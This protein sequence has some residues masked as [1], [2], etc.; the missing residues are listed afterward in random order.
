MK[1]RRATRFV[2]CRS[3]GHSPSRR[4]PIHSRSLVA[5]LALGLVRLSA[6]PEHVQNNQTT[7]ADLSI[8][9]HSNRS[10]DFPEMFSL[11]RLS[12][13]SCSSSGD[14]LHLPQFQGHSHA[15]HG[16]ESLALRAI[17]SAHTVVPRRVLFELLREGD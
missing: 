15:T 1:P 9:I 11:V 7:G 2:Q 5:I 17:Q 14:L 12:H 10:A 16:T 3:I 13:L 4:Y 6:E 8:D